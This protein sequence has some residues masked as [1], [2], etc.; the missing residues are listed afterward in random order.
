MAVFHF[1]SL[2]SSTF[3]NQ[4]SVFYFIFYFL[5]GGGSY[6]RIKH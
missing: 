5:G 3:S 1:L 2:A 6:V 4:F